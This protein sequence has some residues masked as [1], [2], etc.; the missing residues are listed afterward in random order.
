MRLN[1][2]ST[3]N[4]AWFYCK[5]FR[6]GSS[7]LSLIGSGAGAFVSQVISSDNNRKAGDVRP[8]FH[9]A[10]TPA[11][12]V[13]ALE[14]NVS[15]CFPPCVVFDT[16]GSQGRLPTRDQTTFSLAII[17]FSLKW[18]REPAMLPLSLPT[19][20][21]RNYHYRRSCLYSCQLLTGLIHVMACECGS[22]SSSYRLRSRLNHC[23]SESDVA[24]C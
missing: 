15:V 10:V 13:G 16:L 9:P 3:E 24:E 5:S 22:A 14:A 11:S 1:A 2:G 23:P 12:Q 8:L 21:A 6:E 4:V 7:P 19:A 17:V 20:P 18:E